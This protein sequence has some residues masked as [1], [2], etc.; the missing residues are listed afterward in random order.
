MSQFLGSIVILDDTV[1]AEPAEID[2]ADIAIDVAIIALEWNDG[3]VT[4]ANEPIAQQQEFC[5]RIRAEM[6]IGVVNGGLALGGNDLT[7]SGST[8]FCI[9]ALVLY[10]EVAPRGVGAENHVPA[11]DRAVEPGDRRPVGGTEL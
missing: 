5:R 6:D 7:V 10:E 1:V 8:Q 9:V 11:R 2:V 4:E 3:A